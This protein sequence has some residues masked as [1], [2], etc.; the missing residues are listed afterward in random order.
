MF[1]QADAM[2]VCAPNSEIA[3]LFN[4]SITAASHA[5]RDTDEGV[6]ALKAAL[7]RVLSTRTPDGIYLD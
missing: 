2:C 1:P 6:A 3:S 5:A 7:E 4:R